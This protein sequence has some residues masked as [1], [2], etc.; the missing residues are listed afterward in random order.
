MAASTK[1]LFIMY[2]HSCANTVQYILSQKT[3]K[4][5]WVLELLQMGYKRVLNF[6]QNSSSAYSCPVHNSC[7]GMVLEII[8]KIRGKYSVKS[9]PFGR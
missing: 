1:G 5:Q 2:R 6:L 3:K 4:T 8:K 7:I 9:P